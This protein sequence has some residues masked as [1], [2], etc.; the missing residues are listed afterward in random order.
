MKNI[1]VPVDCSPATPRVLDLARE[2]ARSFGAQ[3]H[4]MHVSEIS[5]PV[6]ATAMGY[7]AIGV[8]EIGPLTGVPEVMA[9]AVP[10]DAHKAKLAQWEEEIS[11]D[12]LRVTLHEPTGSVLTEIL[13]QADEA[14]V[15]LIVMGTHGHGAMHNLLVGSVTEGVLKHAKQPVLLVPSRAES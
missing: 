14:H 2:M 7:G 5:T 13:K 8:P 10:D 4:L 9:V 1:L 3:L 6:P 15:D 12:G 11:R